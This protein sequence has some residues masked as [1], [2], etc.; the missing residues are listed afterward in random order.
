MSGIPQFN[1]PAFY[2]AA[3]NLEK[4]GYE[5]Y[6]PAEM[7]SPEIQKASLASEDGSFKNLEDMGYRGTWGDFLREDVKIVAD[8]VDSVVVLPGWTSSRGARLEAFVAMTVQKDVLYYLDGELIPLPPEEVM[9][10]IS[11][12]TIAQGDTTRY[13]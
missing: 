7:D 9:A 5:V 2:E 1:Y 6:N 4:E 10:A 13:G 12:N 11:V 3:A 8:E